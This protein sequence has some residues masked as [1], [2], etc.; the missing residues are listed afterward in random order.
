MTWIKLP[1]K[2]I[3]LAFTSTLAVV[4]SLD[5]FTSVQ[6]QPTELK[7]P[8]LS[9]SVK[10]NAEP[11][12]DGGGGQPNSGRGRGGGTDVRFVP[13]PPSQAGK[14]RGRRSGGASRDDCPA[15]GTPLTALVPDNNLG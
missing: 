4:G 11:P 15:V 5:D 1:L 12:P 6:A 3:A 9:L 14:P 7:H 2:Q 10:Q 8:T 13:P